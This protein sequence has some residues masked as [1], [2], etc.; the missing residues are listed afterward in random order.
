[1]KRGVAI[2]VALML[3]AM[4]LSYFA[5]QPGSDSPIPSIENRGP[6]GAAVL[7]TWLREAS[8]PVIAHDAPLTKLPADVRVLVIAAPAL[9]ELRQDEVD[10]V[11]AFVGAGGTLVYLAARTGAQPALHRWLELHSGDVSPLVSMDGIE[12][13]GGTTVKVRF[14]A[15][16][17]EGVKTIR[18][19]ADRMISLG[20]ADAVPVTEHGAL[21][22]FPEGEGEVWA[23]G[24][25]DLIE[26]ARLE[27]ADNA[28]FWSRLA[29]RGPIAFDEY[30][31]HRGATVMPVNLV[32]TLL[33]VLFLGV[34][35]LWAIGTRLGPPRDEPLTQHRSALEYVRA[36]ATLTANAQVEDELV[37]ALKHDFRRRLAE[38][39]SIPPGWSWEEAATQL[40]KQTGVSR[41]EVLAAARETSFVPLSRALAKLEHALHGAPAAAA[42]RGAG[43]ARG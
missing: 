6:R 13:V 43:R 31:H 42:P 17:L 39:L 14:S 23:A 1:M 10:A 4:A 38:E 29:A 2:I 28:L 26:N 15:G 33:Q 12:D 27:L 36:M 8:V 16:L 7:A 3:L 40:A 20:R 22:W 21:W 32:A 24:G 19:S 11:R 5:R 35:A 18:L 30:H 25:P 34:L 37:V 9:E 41:D